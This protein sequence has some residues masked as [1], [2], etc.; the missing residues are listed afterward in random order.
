MELFVTC[1][2]RVGIPP[3]WHAAQFGGNRPKLCGEGIAVRWSMCSWQTVQLLW[4]SGMWQL[5]QCLF[6][7]APQ[8]A[9]CESGAVVWW[10]FMQKSSS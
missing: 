8:P 3:G 4:R 10:H 1:G 7:G 9:R 2:A 5:M 6:S